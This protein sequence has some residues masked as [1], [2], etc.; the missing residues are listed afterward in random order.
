MNRP[1]VRHASDFQHGDLKKEKILWQAKN[2]WLVLMQVQL[3]LLL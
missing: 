2:F 1:V 3:V